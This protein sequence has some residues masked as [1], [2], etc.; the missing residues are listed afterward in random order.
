MSIKIISSADSAIA[1]GRVG[2]VS[3]HKAVTRKTDFYG[4][5]KTGVTTTKTNLTAM[6][7]LYSLIDSHGYLRAAISVMGRSAV[8]AWWTLTAHKEANSPKELH[9]K[10]LYRFFAEPPGTWTNINDYYSIAYKIA[11]GVMYFKLFVYGVS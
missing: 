11:I 9:R 5:E 6:Q 3:D 10:K 7:D 4:N 8:G 1:T 2:F